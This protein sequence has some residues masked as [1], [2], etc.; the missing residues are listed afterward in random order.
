M[1]LTQKTWILLQLVP[2][3]PSLASLRKPLLCE[4]LNQGDIILGE[5]KSEKYCR[6]KGLSKWNLG[7]KRRYL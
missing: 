7:W 4:E 1:P 2:F 3:S 6:Q 5:I